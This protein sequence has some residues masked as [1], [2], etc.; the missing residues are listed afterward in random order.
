MY[1]SLGN[2]IGWYALN[3]RGF[4]VN[5][6]EFDVFINDLISDQDRS[7]NVSLEDLLKSVLDAKTK[8]TKENI[9]VIINKIILKDIA[10]NVYRI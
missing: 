2:I 10:L 4:P 1:N 9:R 3:G 5:K 8:Y 7:F 6:K